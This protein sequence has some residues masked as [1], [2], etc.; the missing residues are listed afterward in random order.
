MFASVSV[1]FFIILD[2]WQHTKTNEFYIHVHTARDM[3]DDYRQN[4]QSR[5][6][7]KAFILG[8]SVILCVVRRT[9][10]PRC[11]ADQPFPEPT[12]I[13]RRIQVAVDMDDPITVS[14]NSNYYN[15]R[16]KTRSFLN[17]LHHVLQNTFLLMIEPACIIIQK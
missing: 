1:N 13:P 12:H 7:Q 2:V 5:F 15:H 6:A 3:G 8:P 11:C 9:A 4:L 10:A 14:I 17:N 16:K